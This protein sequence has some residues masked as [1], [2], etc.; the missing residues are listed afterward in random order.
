MWY[1]K[2]AA[3]GGGGDDASDGSDTDDDLDDDNHGGGLDDVD[4]DVSRQSVQSYYT[5]D[6][7]E[8]SQF[9]RTDSFDLFLMNQSSL[10]SDGQ[11]SGLKRETL[12]DFEFF[13]PENNCTPKEDKEDDEEDEHSE[14][15]KEEQAEEI[16]IRGQE[17]GADDKPK[18][19]QVGHG[20]RN[21][22]IRKVR[23]KYI[24]KYQSERESWEV[25]LNLNRMDHGVNSFHQALVNTF[26]EILD[27]V[28][29]YMQDNDRIRFV[30]NHPAQ[31]RP[32]NLPLMRRGDVD[33]ERIMSE[34]ERV[35]QSN[36]GF[37]INDLFTMDI[38]KVHLPEGTKF[39]NRSVPISKLLQSKKSI[40]TI[41]NND[42]MCMARAL[43]T[44]IAKV[45]DDP[46]WKS[47][48]DSRCG[49][50]QLQKQMARLEWIPTRWL[51][52]LMSESFSQ[53]W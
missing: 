14:N 32:I 50:D 28:A 12:D 24:Q 36:E 4:P 26:N 3:G 53:N 25:Q 46:R 37:D 21:Y 31:N 5:G 34:I 2:A 11:D 51:E 22:T 7:D 23:S 42:N 19:S 40:V 35:I 18:Q 38:I 15:D 8:Y 6:Q 1:R 16:G 47:I 17:G 49:R 30:F 43:V 20:R 39:M 48:S 27:R 13:V 41:K 33:A 52:Y 10:T 45:D 9:Y 44:A 29:G